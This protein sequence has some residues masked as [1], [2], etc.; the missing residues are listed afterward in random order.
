MD[1]QRAETAMMHYVEKSLQPTQARDLAAH[2]IECAPCRSLYLL[3]DEAAELPAHTEAPVASSAAPQL[4]AAP[5]DFT[6]R[7]MARIQAE[8][9]PAPVQAA[10]QDTAPAEAS[11]GLRILWGFSGIFM[12]FALLLAFNPQW[13]VAIT[14]QD[15]LSSATAFFYDVLAR[16]AQV[17]IIEMLA[18]SWLGAVALVFAGVIAASLYGL[19]RGENPQGSFHA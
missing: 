5:A 4:T 19:H 9:S 17:Q 3:L 18:E 12:G 2:V 7:V 11:A 10:T 1:C 8:A 13:A 15:A 6:N 14:M 16:V